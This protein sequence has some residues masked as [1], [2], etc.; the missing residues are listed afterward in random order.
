ML[1]QYFGI[2]ELYQVSLKANSFMN[3]GTR[4]IE[5]GEPVLYFEK[6]NIAL[7]TEN[8]KPIF[9]RGGRGNMPRVIWEDRSEVNFSLTE[10]VMSN[11]GLGI[12][13]SA[14]VLGK[15]EKD[16]IYVPKK[17][18][19]FELDDNDSYLLKYVPSKDKKIYVFSYFRNCIQEK[20][21]YTIDGQKITILNSDP[22]ERYVVDYYFEYGE[23]DFLR[24]L[25]EKDRFSGTFLLEGKFYS[26]DENDGLNY[27]NIITMPKVRIVSSMNLRLGER[28]EPTVSTFNI[29]G[30][31]DKVRD[32]KDLIMEI[33][34]L[35]EDIDG[36]I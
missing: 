31:P 21:E 36:D 29:V 3:F 30:M 26:K 5:K 32:S 11:I 35:N 17:E 8:S 4:E 10:G 25:I 9:A 2:K 7:L 20:K 33:I 15:S 19:P 6:V 24:Y 18:G 14:N 22:T 16:I 12:L 28:A 23:K 13:T 27:T 34:T 1:D